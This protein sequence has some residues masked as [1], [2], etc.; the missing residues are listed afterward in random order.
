M[1]FYVDH[2]HVD[3]SNKK[4]LNF[5]SFPF[6]DQTI[7]EKKRPARKDAIARDSS[8]TFQRNLS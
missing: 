6:F 5:L 1:A 2:M 7:A 4:K 3:R 8:S